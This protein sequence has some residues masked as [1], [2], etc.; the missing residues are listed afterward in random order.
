MVLLLVVVVVVAIVCSSLIDVI[1]PCKKLR[2]G[3][4][5]LITYLTYLVLT[6]PDRMSVVERYLRRSEDSEE[7]SN[8]QCICMIKLMI[9]LVGVEVSK[10]M[11]H[12][13]K[14]VVYMANR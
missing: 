9:V 8:F 3:E 5:V 12:G 6:C 4:R 1:T 14:G 10:I 11:M 2:R 13:T 7:S